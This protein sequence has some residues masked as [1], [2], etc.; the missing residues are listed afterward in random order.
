MRVVSLLE[1]GSNFESI[2]DG[3][4]DDAVTTVVTRC[5]SEPVVA[6]SLEQYNRLMELIQAQ[7]EL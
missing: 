4:V 6:M 5:G 2:L 3:V 1:D 7:Q